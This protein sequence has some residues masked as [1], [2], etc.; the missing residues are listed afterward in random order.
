MAAEGELGKAR[1]PLDHDADIDAIDDEYCSTRLGVAAR[2]GQEAMVE[3]L[4][5]RGADPVAAGASWGTPLAWAEKRGHQRIAEML[6]VAP[7][8]HGLR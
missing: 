8:T 3:R 2:R 1:L 7:S 5:Q 6:R 4:L